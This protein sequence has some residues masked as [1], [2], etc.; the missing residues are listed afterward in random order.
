[1]SL[2]EA[3]AE[4]GALPDSWIRAWIRAQLRAGRTPPPLARAAVPGQPPLELPAA[5]FEPW[6]G[7]RMKL[8]CG[9]WPTPTTTLAES[10]AAMLALTCERAGL[11]PGMRVLD[12]GAG[13]GALA[14]WIAERDPSAQVLALSNSEA[15]TACVR[16]R[17]AERGDANVTVE[18]GDARTFETRQRFDRI[19]AIELLEHVA[20]PGAVLARALSWLAPGGRL[21]VQGLAGPRTARGHLTPERAWAVDGR[22]Y[23]R[24]LE[25]WLGSADRLRSTRPGRRWRLLLLACAEAFSWPGPGGWRLEHALFAPGCM[26][27]AENARPLLPGTPGK[28]Y[29]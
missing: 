1:M 25:A 2:V 7:P 21:F 12:L 3:L 29:D 23:A 6:L 8:S 20:D 18:R 4:A 27:G 17:V 15:E 13:F 5:F 26:S 24:T 28:P 14:L 16:T 9:R 22:E 11:A 19:L 10:E